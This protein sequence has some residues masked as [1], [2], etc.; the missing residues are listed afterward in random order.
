[1]SN[2]LLFKY[3]GAMYYRTRSKFC[4]DDFEFIAQTL[5]RTSEEKADLLRLTEDPYALQ[6]LLRDRRL[7]DRS[8]TTPPA[9]VSISPHFFF[10]TF[11]YRALE[12]KGIGDDDVADYVAGICVDFRS[13]E[14][15]W[16]FSTSGEKTI[17]IVDLLNLMN[18]LD[19]TQRYFLRLYIGNTT[20]FLTGFFPDHIFQR[21]RKK[22]AP[23]IEYYES[24]GRVQ[25]ETAA[26]QSQAYDDKAVPVLSTLAE[27]FIDVRLAMNVYTDAYLD[28]HSR[29]GTLETIERQAS[30]LDE[31]SFRQS[32][33][34]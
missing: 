10:Y 13:N 18:D 32:L 25:Y 24:I 12:H 26:T 27:R 16:H 6:Q 31:E 14:G 2:N 15:L 29:K 20:L 23:P 28:L 21:N 33:S 3:R 1:M 11:I 9:F 19:E 8:M 4:R 30:T 22:G 7:F 34:I 5:G 17:Y